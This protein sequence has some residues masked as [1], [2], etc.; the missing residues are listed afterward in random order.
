MEAEGKRNVG[1]SAALGDRQA[2]S[3]VSGIPG[4]GKREIVPTRVG[5]AMNSLS[6]RL[7]P[8]QTGGPGPLRRL[9]GQTCGLEAT[10]WV[11]ASE[12]P[13]V[14]RSAIEPM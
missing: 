3:A 8:C 4:L 1:H 9:L 11:G 14:S 12:L 13:P 7:P 10:R 6:S 5:R 2:R